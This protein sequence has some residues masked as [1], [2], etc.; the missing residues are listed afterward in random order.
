MFVLVRSRQNSVGLANKTG[1]ENEGR[2][3][4]FVLSLTT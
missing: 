3:L 4:F 2:P 1:F